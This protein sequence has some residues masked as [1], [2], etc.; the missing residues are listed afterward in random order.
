MAR[1][2]AALSPES[3]FYRFFSVSQPSDRSIDSF[4]DNTNPQA[5]LTLVIHRL[6]NGNVQ[7]VAAGSYIAH[8]PTTAEIALAVGDRLQGKGIGTLLLERLAMLAVMNDF[9]R[10]WAVT[11]AENKPMLDVFRNS[12]FKLARASDGYVEIDL[13]VIPSEASVG[14]AEMRDRISTTASLK[15]MC[16]AMICCNI[17]K[18]TSRPRPS[19]G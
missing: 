12:G 17:G 6:V 18:R 9:R 10:F 13:S 7:I 16:R 19:P 8:D 4:C 2:F 5:R 3:K 14:R 1:V 11:M 15:P